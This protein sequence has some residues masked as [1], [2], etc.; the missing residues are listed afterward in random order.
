M[1]IAVIPEINFGSK[2]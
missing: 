2:R 1:Y